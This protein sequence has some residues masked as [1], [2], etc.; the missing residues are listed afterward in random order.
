MRVEWRQTG[1]LCKRARCYVRFTVQQDG[2]VRC[3]IYATTRRH[4][5]ASIRALVDVHYGRR[6]ATGL[7]N[8]FDASD[9][10]GIA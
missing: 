1:L 7:Y 2:R 8:F 5:A 3:C 9:V 4:C 10:F 6:R